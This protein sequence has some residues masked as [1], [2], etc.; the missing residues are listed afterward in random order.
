M[1]SLSSFVK[2][3]SRFAPLFVTAVTDAGPNDLEPEVLLVLAVVVGDDLLGGDRVVG[4]FETQAELGHSRKV[5][6]VVSGSEPQRFPA[7]LPC[8]ARSWSAIEHHEIVAGVEP[9]SFQVER[10]R[11]PRLART[12]DDNRGVRSRCSHGSTLLAPP[13]DG[14]T[15]NGRHQFGVIM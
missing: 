10:D 7:K 11:Q 12:D 15:S 3:T 9:E 1:S 6:D 2:V 8:A 14:T 5:V 13:I 4:G